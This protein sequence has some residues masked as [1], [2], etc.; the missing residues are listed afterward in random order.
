MKTKIFE[1]PFFNFFETH[2]SSAKFY[3]D[4]EYVIS[5]VIGCILLR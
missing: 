3:V 4:S 1:N 5:F 2:L